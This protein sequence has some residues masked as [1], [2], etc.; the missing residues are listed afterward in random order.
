M[1]FIDKGVLI[2]VKLNAKSMPVLPKYKKLNNLYGKQQYVFEVKDGYF[3]CNREMKDNLL[4]KQSSFMG[5]IKIFWRKYA[6]LG[7]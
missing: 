6:K 4:K 1:T 7:F 5:R 3:V 2:K